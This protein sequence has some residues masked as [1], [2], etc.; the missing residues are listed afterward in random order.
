MKPGTVLRI[1]SVPGN[2][3]SVIG[4]CSAAYH[5][6]YRTTNAL[7]QP[8]WAVTTLYI[9]EHSAG[10]SLLSYQYPYN[11]P[12]L[13]HSPSYDFYFEPSGD[14]GEALGLGL[15]V[16]V[17]DHEGPLAADGATLGQGL[18]TLDSVRAVLSTGFGLSS[19]AR[20]AMWGYSGGALA[21]EWAAELQEQYAP[22][23]SFS[24][25]ALGGTPPNITNVWDSVNG[26]PFAGMIALASIGVTQQF[27]DA[28]K[29][30]I[31]QLK[32]EGEYNRTTYM[33]AAKMGAYEGFATF[34]GQDMWDYFINGRA[35]LGA[36]VIQRVLDDNFYMSYH[37]VP[38]MRLF[39]YHAI[40]DQVAR[41]ELTDNLVARYCGVHTNIHYE[42]NTIGDHVG[43]M[44]NGQPRALAWLSGV[45]DGTNTASSSGCTIMN[46]TVGES[47]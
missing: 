29:Y 26:T 33:S 43:E 7:F 11:S 13:D 36:P 24:G 9:P 30:L 12:D 32:P 8:S 20:Y 37:G 18:A 22:E 6:L 31:S 46:V 27:P 45:L 5:I 42:R 25:T 28:H 39:M 19:N 21:S 41:I 3:T 35:V 38:K 1:R 10:K 4:N 17:P 14:V 34:A 44:T 15:Y 47:S 16:S 40:H 23:L 2:L